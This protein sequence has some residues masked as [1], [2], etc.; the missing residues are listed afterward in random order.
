MIHSSIYI[1]SRHIICVEKILSSWKLKILIT[2][3]SRSMIQLTAASYCS[4]REPMFWCLFL[5][6]HMS[7]LIL[8]IS[9]FI[10][11]DFQFSHLRIVSMFVCIVWNVPW[12]LVPV[13]RKATLV[14]PKWWLQKSTY[15]E[16]IPERSQDQEKVELLVIEALTISVT[17]AKNYHNT[18]NGC[19]NIES[20]H[21]FSSSG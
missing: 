2:L 19:D 10:L 8:H 21:C 17:H 12:M 20:A 15:L 4:C 14:I 16:T 6:L 5:L 18:F 3:P 7:Y 11:I 1:P 9:Y 13:L